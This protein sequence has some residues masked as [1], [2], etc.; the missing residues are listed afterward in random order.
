MSLRSTKKI[1]R[2]YWYIVLM[3]DTVIDQ[4]NLLVKYQQEI[5]VFTDSKV[6]IIGDGDVEITGL[7]RNGDGNKAPL[8]IKN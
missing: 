1:T 8:K 5:L 2:R 3:P 6:L 4:V 7:N